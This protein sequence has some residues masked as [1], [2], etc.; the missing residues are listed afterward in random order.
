MHSCHGL[1]PIII[2]VIIA[3]L[4]MPKELM[5]LA[6]CAIVVILVVCILALTKSLDII[7]TRMKIY[8][9]KNRYPQCQHPTCITCCM[10]C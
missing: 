6:T 2:I 1:V 5:L 9:P 4:L 8:K 10:T 7:V 3:L